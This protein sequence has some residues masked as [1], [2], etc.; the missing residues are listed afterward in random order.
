[1]HPRFYILPPTALVIENVYLQTQKA[2][3]AC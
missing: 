3:R 2:I 1:M